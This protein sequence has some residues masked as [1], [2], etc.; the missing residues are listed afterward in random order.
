LQDENQVF[1]RHT[2]MAYTDA[3]T[4]ALS[5]CLPRGTRVEFDFEHLFKADVAARYNYYQTAIAAGILTAD[6]VRTKEGLDV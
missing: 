2:L 1:F 3:I 4:D 5:N 6:E